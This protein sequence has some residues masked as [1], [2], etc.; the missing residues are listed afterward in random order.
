MQEIRE[1]YTLS[2]VFKNAQ[3][4]IKYLFSKWV[5]IIVFSIFC[6]LIGLGIRWYIGPVYR[7]TMTFVSENGSADGLGGYASI[8]SSFGFDLGQGGGGAF[9]GDNLMEV[10]KSRK[11][12]VAT[13]LSPINEENPSALLITRFIKTHNIDKKWS[14]NSEL[15][16][17]SFYSEINKPNRQRDSLITLV[18]D[19]VVKKNLSVDRKDKKLNFIDIE[20]DDYDE[21]FAKIFVEKLSAN[22]IKFYTE[23]K[24]KKTIASLNSIQKQCD[25]LR[26]LLYGSISQV[27]S[28]SDL[29]VNPSKQV[30]KSNTQK[31]QVNVQANTA[32]YTEGLKQL[33]IA[34]IT[35]QKETPLIQIIDAPIY[36]LKIVNLSK[37][38]SAVLAFILGLVL[39]SIF[40]VVKLNSSEK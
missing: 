1:E 33:A 20:V 12:V 40:L 28:I 27:A 38:W 13:L 39:S 23:Y 17:A 4:T 16:K 32:M 3:T 25:S 10:L 30:L 22:A 19:K 6:G 34:K 29:N 15:Q 8:A 36:P 2:E 11:L 14:A 7:G 31:E 24:T 5:L 21:E 26:N 35:L 9:E 37:V 18:Y